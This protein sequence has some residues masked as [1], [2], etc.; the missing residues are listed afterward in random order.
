MV[1]GMQGRAMSVRR[2]RRWTALAA[3]GGIAIALVVGPP[4]SPA[5]GEAARARATSALMNVASSAAPF[6]HNLQAWPTM[7]VDPVNTHVLAATANEWADM[8]P[9]SKQA[10]TTGAGCGLPA[11]NPNFGGASNRGV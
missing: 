5:T 8:Q 6:Q 1:R 3:V 2:I 9:C 4:T 7:A 10:A 11:A